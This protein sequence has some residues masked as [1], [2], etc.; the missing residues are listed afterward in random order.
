MI[1]WTTISFAGCSKVELSQLGARPVTLE[2]SPA[3]LSLISTDQ[4][5]IGVYI[6]PPFEY[7]KRTYYQMM[8]DANVD[9]IQEI[10]GWIQPADK[11][12]ML[13]LADSVGLK[14][15]VDDDR[16][17]GTD[18]QITDMV[19]TYKNHPAVMG[20][21]IKDEPTVSQLNDAATRY[22]KVLSNDAAKLVHVNLLPSSATGL[23][24]SIDY[25]NDYVKKWIDLVGAANLKYLSMDDYPFLSNGQ[26]QQDPYY[27]SL[28]VIRKLGLQFHVKTAAYMQ[29]VGVAGS[30]RRPNTDELRFSAYS[31]LAYGIKIPV[32][33]TYWTPT[34]G[35]QTFT[36]AIVDATGAVT[37][38]YTPFQILN[39]ELKQ[40]GKTL[41][42]L[43][44]VAVYHA[45]SSIPTG[46]S[47]IPLSFMVQPVDAAANIIMTY[48]VNQTNGKEYVMIVNKSLN[49]GL[50]T[51]FSTGNNITNVQ[52]I[53]KTNGDVV[54]TNFN[55]ATHQFSASFLPGEGILF[56]L[57]TVSPSVAVSTLSGS[58]GMGFLD[59]AATT[60]KFNF[61]T[62][63]GMAMD[64]Q[65][66]A[67]IAD[68]NNHCIRKVA[69]SGSVSTLAG[70][71]GVAGNTDGTGT[72]ARFDHPAD[73][74]V[75][76]YGNVYV[77][78]SWNWAIRKITPAGTVSTILGWTVPFPQGIAIDQTQQKIYAVSA[79]PGSSNG[80]LFELSFSGVLTVRTLDRAVT[81]GSIKLDNNGKLI[82]ADN[83]NSVV[84]RI[85]RSTWQ[86]EVLAGVAGQHGNIDGVGTSARFD[87]P[88]GLAIDADNN[89]YVA[90]CGHQFNGDTI[91]GS[92]SNIR[93]IQA[94]SNKVIT[95][96]GTG[97]R[98]YTDGS[99]SSAKFNVPTGI[100]V[101]QNQI[102][103]L[104]REN[105]RI[106][107]LV[108]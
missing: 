67:Y 8:K 99:G 22:N 76:S 3:S 66:N 7:T 27:Y 18:A 78:D 10:A 43:D 81:A 82:V 79:L 26:F 20:Y 4:L 97:M 25:E 33:F 38:L 49:T 13:N 9:F 41:I 5:P 68:I 12:T 60:A 59:G 15:I 69:A 63:T 89:I 11:L 92:A 87:H 72:A 31:T 48:F 108:K 98:G 57:T 28:D 88:W 84:Y 17:N 46:A 65:G 23:L 42:N 71:P 6:A 21:F 90:G 91:S 14:M 101:F 77:A 53:S 56:P 96:A 61:V 85:N 100:A 19:N 47:T 104:D 29:S 35:A 94:N 2:K 74:A 107:K 55:P 32:W 58:G 16:V 30:L 93:M 75:D 80:K 95:L 62:N 73:V 64:N 54:A 51:T 70:N 36:D 102:L 50:N 37:N 106:R 44:A 1:C 83:F 34:G 24:G 105:Q 86:T 40:V 45:G 39:A 52:W 103:V